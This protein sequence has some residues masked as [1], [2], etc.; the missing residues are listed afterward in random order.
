MWLVSESPG[1]ILAGKGSALLGGTGALSI[2]ASILWV[3]LQTVHTDANEAGALAQTAI[4]VAAQHGD[5]FVAVRQEL[6]ELVV[7][8]ADLKAQ[9]SIGGRFT[10]ADG[11]QLRQQIHELQ[12]DVIQLQREV[13][14]VLPVQATPPQP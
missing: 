10:R 8:I 2:L 5:E 9:M 1:G 14:R 4:K 6:R 11:Q 7:A 3:Q 13:A 12:R